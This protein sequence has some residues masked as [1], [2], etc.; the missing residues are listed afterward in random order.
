MLGRGM[1]MML[2]PNARWPILYELKVAMGNPSLLREIEHQTLP[3]QIEPW[4]LEHSVE[5]W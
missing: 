1:G 4:P 2:G 5:R 3:G